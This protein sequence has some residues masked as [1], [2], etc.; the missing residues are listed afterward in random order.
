MIYVGLLME[1]SSFNQRFERRVRPH[2]PLEAAF[3][4]S[5]IERR[6]VPAGEVAG[7]V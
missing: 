1:E 4:R 5:Y 7:N 6:K 3:G 2:R